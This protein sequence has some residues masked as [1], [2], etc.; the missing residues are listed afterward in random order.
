MRRFGKNVEESITKGPTHDMTTLILMNPGI[1]TK[2]QH[3]VAI[4]TLM[5]LR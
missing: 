5:F 3:A 4:S 1:L 2:E